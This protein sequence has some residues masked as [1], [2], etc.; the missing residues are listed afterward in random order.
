MFFATLTREQIEKIYNECM[1][2]DFPPNELKPLAMIFKAME[3]GVY[4]CYGLMEEDEV[5]GYAFLLKLRDSEDYLIDYIATNQKKRNQGLG[6]VILKELR[7]LLKD[8]DSV[9]GEVENPDLA[10]S[11]EERTL[12]KRRYQFYMRNGLLDTG[13]LATCFGVPFIILEQTCS[14]AHTKEEIISLYKAHYQAL[15]P[16]TMYEKNIRI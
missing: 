10:D 11:E 5:L 13:V 14:K 4:F 9:I 3:E 16:K 15:L 8:A 6:A 7:E 12:Q 2:V 1:K